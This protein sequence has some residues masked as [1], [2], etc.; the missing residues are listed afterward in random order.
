MQRRSIMRAATG[1]GAI[2]AFGVALTGCSLLGLGQS[3]DSVFDLAVGDCTDDSD[4]VSGDGTITNMPRLDCD[5]PHTDEVYHAFDMPDGD[6]PG[7]DA[8]AS[9][10]DEECTSAFESFIGIPY[11]ESELYF[12]TI[13]PTEETWD[14]LDDREVLCL[15]YDPTVDTLSE[16]LEGAAR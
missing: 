7:A 16:S 4:V 11:L 9:A 5:E 3:G 8:I 6:F 13:T 14:S 1:V 2:A 12:W 15:V 10:G